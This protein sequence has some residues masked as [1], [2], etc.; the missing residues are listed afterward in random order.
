LIILGFVTAMYF[1]D[2]REMMIDNAMPVLQP[3]LVWNAER[4]LGEFSRAVKREHRTTYQPPPTRQW[5]AWLA[6]NFT[7]DVATD[8]WGTTYSYQAWADSFAIRSD[9][10]DG[11]RASQD[12][13]RMVW[14][15][16]F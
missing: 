3:M 12:D 13:L 14:H 4:E 16:P 2:S 6:T 9:G 7:G 15:R 10:P 8:L 11:Q 1:P 5:N